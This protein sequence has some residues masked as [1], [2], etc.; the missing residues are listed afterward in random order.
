MRPTRCRHFRGLYGG[1]KA[2]AIGID[3]RGLFGAGVIGWG[4]RIPCTAPAGAESRVA[5]SGHD[6][7]SQDELAAED[8]DGKVAAAQSLSVLAHA[9]KTYDDTKATSGSMDCPR[10]GAKLRWAVYPGKRHHGVRAACTKF[11]CMVLMT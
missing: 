11:G 8:K 3:V 2:C 5:C 6:Q 7:L 1:D 4:T 10:C 9:L